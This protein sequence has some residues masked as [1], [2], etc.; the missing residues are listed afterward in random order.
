MKKIIMFIGA[1]GMNNMELA[2][3]LQV[4]KYPKSIIID[5]YDSWLR[6]PQ[7][8][9]SS[10]I[11]EQDLYETT[12]KAL[13]DTDVVMLVAPF[14][15]KVD[16]DNFFF[17]L[18]QTFQ[19]RIKVIGVWVERKYDDLKIL[20]QLRLPYRQVPDETFEYLYKYRESPSP[21]EPFDDIVYITREINTGM[22]KNKPYIT[23]ILTALDRI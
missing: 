4:T 9:Y 17:Y 18:S 2:H 6:Y 22:S 11:V 7:E 16:R 15:L 10:D 20:R 14:V 1:P 12:K 13:H 23:D 19:E 5:R 3:Y 8:R 21:D